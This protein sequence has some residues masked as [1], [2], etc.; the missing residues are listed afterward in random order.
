ML[1][2]GCAAQVAQARAPGKVPALGLHLLRG[3]VC[4]AE[5]RLDDAAR[6][7]E[8]ELSEADPGQLY[9]H[10]CAAN[11]WYALGA[12][13]LRQ[14]RRHEAESAFEQAL[15][16]AP[17]HLCAAAAM[18]RPLPVLNSD[19]PRCADAATAHAIRLALAGRHPEGALAFMD[20]LAALPSPAAGWILPV[21]PLLNTVARPSFWADAL[22]IVRQRA[23]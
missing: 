12:A 17:G 9:A 3:L 20:A 4:A 6:A 16:T 18:G 2:E 5:D 8:M 23:V 13:R 1:R 21:E 11:A 14:R 19:D 7:C 22:A 10:E 15:A